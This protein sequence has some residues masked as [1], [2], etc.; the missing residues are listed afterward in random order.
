M[1]DRQA[2]SKHAERVLGGSWDLVTTSN[3]A[4]NPGLTQKRPVRETVG[5]V[6][7]PVSSGC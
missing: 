1:Q 4:Y 2:T 3:W 5:R 7:S 6:K